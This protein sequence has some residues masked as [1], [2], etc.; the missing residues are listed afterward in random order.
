VFRQWLLPP[1]ICLLLAFCF[2][3]A[4]R[5][6]DLSLYLG[7]RVTRVDVILEGVASGGTGEIRS[8]LEVSA[9]QDFSPLRIR[10]SLARLYKSGLIS[11]A[12]VEALEDGSSGVAIRFVVR[13]QARI[14]KVSFEGNTVVASSELRARLH[15]L[16]L[17]EKLSESV[18]NRGTGELV[19]FYASRG[20]YQAAITPQVRLDS[21]GTRATVVYRVAP[22]EAARVSR[23]TVDFKGARLDLSRIKRAIVEGAPF[24]EAAVQEDMERIRQAYLQSDYLAVKISHNVAVDMISNSVAVTLHCESGPM[25]EVEVVGIEL[26]DKEKRKILTFYQTGGIDDLALDDGRR[27]LLD[28]AQRRGYF[29]A[30]IALPDPPDLQQEKARITYHV[31]T[32]ARYRLTDIEFEG[33]EAIPL[34][35]LEEQLK[36]KRAAFLPL[37]GPGRGFTSNELLRQD[38]LLIQK[39]LYELGYRR[40]DVSFRRGVSVAGEN[41]IITFEVKQG[42]RSYID[43][44]E[45][46]GNTIFTQQELRERLTIK[47]GDPFMAGAASQN[48]DALLSVYNLG[49]YAGAQVFSELI[50]V[51]TGEDGDRVRLIFSISEGNRIRIRSVTTR[52]LTNV[53]A[54]R[55]EK[56]FYLFK[57]GEWLRNDRLQ[58]TERVLYE[59]DAFQTVAINSELVGQ[60]ADGIEEHAVTVDLIESKRYLLIYGFGYQ[61]SQSDLEVPGLGFLAG[62]R[63]NVQLT[64]VNILGKLYTGSLQLRASRSELLGQVSFQNPRPFGYDYPAQFSIFARRLAEKSFRSDRYTSILQVE[65]RLSPE[66]IAYINYTFERIK[67]FDLQ[68]SL[69]EIERNRRPIRLG[70]V[71]VSYARDTRDNAFDSTRGTFT[72]GSLSFASTVFGGNEQFIKF[73]AEHTRYYPIKLLRNTVFL[74]SARVGLAAPFGGRDSLPISERFFGGGSRDLRGF[75]FEEAGPRDATTGRPLGGNALLVINNELKFPITGILGGAVFSDTGNVFRRMKDFRPQKLSQS[76]GFGILAK[77]PIGPVRVDIAFLVFNRPAGE[78]VMRRH[79]TFG[80]T[81]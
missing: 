23:S 59:T 34:D 24:T 56:D 77:T 47:P 42:P 54:A 50:D 10:D 12:K 78:P 39:Q 60:A 31:E 22:G 38:S 2:I 74:T 43:S 36:S 29:F 18:I 64:N 8:L 46:R 58:E 71:G 32:G 40:A 69:D 80:Q 70:R 76:L 72:F 37:V 33:L 53:K 9:G 6:D 11:G 15:E 14:E 73:N 66:S 62:A 61:T 16:N 20:Y 55:L 41:L 52:G 63:G 30:E 1:V 17:G 67:I 65:R 13:P 25:V 28:Y 3:S 26:D 7:R 51:G 81:F 57:T 45:V 27:R 49:G 19:T 21:S 75:G 5:A 44:L 4:A 79:F 35:R 48:A 68:T